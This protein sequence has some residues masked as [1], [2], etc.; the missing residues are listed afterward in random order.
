MIKELNTKNIEATNNELLAERIENVLKET[1][2][3]D[4]V[5]YYCTLLYTKECDKG[6][7]GC[8][9]LDYEVKW[10]GKDIINFMRKMQ[11]M[12]RTRWKEKPPVLQATGFKNK[13]QLM[14]YL[15]ITEKKSCEMDLTEERELIYGKDYWLGDMYREGDLACGDD[16]FIHLWNRIKD[17]AAKVS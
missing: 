12:S 4:E 17:K 14:K 9:C 1:F 3:W 13:G 15:E 7:N 2:D 6:K 5:N 10:F 11:N 16:L 8:A